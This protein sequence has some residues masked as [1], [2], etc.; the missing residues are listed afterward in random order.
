MFKKSLLALMLATTSG[1][2]FANEA[3]ISALKN[4][5]KAQQSQID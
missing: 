4:Q 5:L 2:T 1:A 3:E